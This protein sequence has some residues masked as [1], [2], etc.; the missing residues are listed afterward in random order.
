MKNVMKA[1]VL[2]QYGGPESV[3]VEKVTKPTPADNEILVRVYASAINSADVRLRKADPFVIRFMLGVF[4]P[5]DAILGMDFSGVVESVGKSVTRFNPGDE[6]FGSTVAS[7]MKA[8]AEYLTIAEKGLVLTKPHILTHEEAPSFYFGGSASLHFLKKGGIKSGDSVLIYGA[9]GALGVYAVQLAKYFG[10]E[11]T[12]VSSG[13]NIPMLR[14]LGADHTLDYTKGE[15]ESNQDEYD[16]IYDTIGKSPFGESVRLLKKKGKYLRAVHL[17]PGVML[18]GLW[19]NLTTSK[20]VIGG[21]AS[22]NKEDLEF[23]TTLM[24]EQHLQP[25]V[26]RTFS[27]DNIQEAHAYV[28]EGHKRGSV[29]VKMT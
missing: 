18:R 24:D 8:H 20:K 5:K 14:E 6:V 12:T 23:L 7:G 11:V 3:Q 13:R 29:I 2:K 22:D 21:V 19:V 27:L 10:A 15:Y 28:G 1:A 4:G 9:S 17:S 26:D 25:V 16:I